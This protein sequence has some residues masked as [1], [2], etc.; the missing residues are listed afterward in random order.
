VFVKPIEQERARRMRRDEGRS[1]REIARLL[2]VSVDSVSRWTAD[3]ALSP[4]F[5]EA[6]RQRNP[7]I[8]DQLKGARE[9]SVAKRRARLA[10]QQEG[11]ER[12]RSPTRL[13]LAGCMLYWAEGSKDR[14][15]VKLTN[16]DPDLL[17]LFVR[18]LRQCYGIAPE[19]IKLSV[20]CH[21]NNG[22]DLAAIEAWWLERLGLPAACLRKASVNRFSRASRWR[23]N[24]LLY[25]TASVSVYST[26]VV[27][28][29]YGAI[30]EYA[31]IERPEWVHGRPPS[32]SP[33][34]I[35]GQRW[36]DDARLM[37]AD[38]SRCPE[39]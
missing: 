7:A 13:H 37:G 6:L 24:V 32:V 17:A 27:Q 21:L 16:S 25:G 9:Q 26:A 33:P 8:N 38:V 2:G 10:Q 18:F 14:N 29:I 28:S 36:H 15:R 22:L 23:R 31:G 19:R 12:A 39:Q 11:R 34:Y 30:Q 4:A 1:V 3:I 35:N 5:A 20:N